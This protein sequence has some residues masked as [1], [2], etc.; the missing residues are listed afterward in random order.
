MNNYNIVTDESKL[1]TIC[2]PISNETPQYMNNLIN[3]MVKLMIES[4]G[5]GI[6]APQVGVNKRLFLAVLDNEKIELFVNPSMVS[7]SEETDIDNEGCL[8][9]PD[10]HGKVE[11][12]SSVKVKYFNGKENKTEH[13]KE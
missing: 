9:V 12:Y 13:L 2:S 10:K 4:N 5:C 11:R 6:A 7:H 1:R 3:G 8:S